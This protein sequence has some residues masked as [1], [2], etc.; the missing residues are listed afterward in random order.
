MDNLVNYSDS[1]SESGSEQS[2][3]AS[4]CAKRL[5]LSSESN[6]DGEKKNTPTSPTT[7]PS[8]RKLDVLLKK[9][10]KVDLK[11]NRIRPAPTDA[12]DVHG[13]RVRSFPHEEG[14]WATHVYVP[15][16]L[17]QLITQKDDN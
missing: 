3:R 14:N 8:A 12:Q 4:P 6:G 7:L 1:D 9:D 13:G 15:S 11:L 16:E 2:A 10:L 5:R 17:M